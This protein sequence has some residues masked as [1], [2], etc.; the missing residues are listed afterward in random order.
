MRKST[1][2]IRKF[3]GIPT[4]Y[5]TKRTTGTDERWDLIR[6]NLGP[7]DKSLLDVGCNLGVLSRKAADAGLAVIGVDTMPNAVL[8]ARRAHRDVPGLAFMQLDIN[9]DTVGRLPRCDVVFCLSVHHYWIANYGQEKAWSMIQQLIAGSQNKLFFEP[10]SR[11]KKYGAN[12]PDFI[13]LD[14]DSLR[15][16]HLE[17]LRDVAGP[18][19]SVEC[20]GATDCI[21][22]EPF[23]LMFVVS[24][25]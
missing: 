20:L 21:G 2:K 24:A 10:A 15:S 16:H 17:R 14:Q 18:Q 7:S 8:S 12:A 6:A 11:R 9:P 19:R 4:L 23:R 25:K 3:L 13:D 22:P 1:R 5:Q